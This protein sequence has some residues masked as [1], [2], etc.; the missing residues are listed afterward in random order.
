MFAKQDKLVCPTRNKI[1]QIK[2]E[3]TFDEHTSD[4]A[5]FYWAAAFLLRIPG[6]DFL[7]KSNRTQKKLQQ[8]L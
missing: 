8:K 7:R 4:H 6:N 2:P 1:L 5:G 3:A